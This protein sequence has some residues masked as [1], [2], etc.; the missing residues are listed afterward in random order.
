MQCL[1][2]NRVG[3]THKDIQVLSDTA[4]LKAI[5]ENLERMRR[6]IRIPD[7][8]VVRRGGIKIGRWKNLKAGENVTMGNFL[9]ALRGLGKLHLIEPLG[10]HESKPSPMELVRTASIWNSSSS[11]PCTTSWGRLESVCPA[12]RPNESG[13]PANHW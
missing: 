5:G 3:N 12:L 6:E 4:I 1:S 9:K 13:C 10:T 7:S 8:E 11:E 2:F